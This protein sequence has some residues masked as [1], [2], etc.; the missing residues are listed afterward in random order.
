[1]PDVILTDLFCGCTEYADSGYDE[2]IL[3]YYTGKQRLVLP[4]KLPPNVFIFHARPILCSVL[5]SIVH[6]VE[7]R[8]CLPEDFKA[9]HDAESA[10]LRVSALYLYTLRMYLE[11]HKHLLCLENCLVKVDG[12]SVAYTRSCRPQPPELQAHAQSCRQ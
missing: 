9:V 11:S 3:I 7:S 4:T 8:E 10:V 6:S 2:W 12:D 5:S 1:M